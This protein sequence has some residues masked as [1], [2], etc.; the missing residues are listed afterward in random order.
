MISLETKIL[1]ASEHYF[2]RIV[3]IRR[4]LH[5]HPELSFEEKNTSAYVF[6]ILKDLGLDVKAGLGGYGLVAV[7]EGDENGPCI[8][9]RADMDALPIQE[10]NQVSYKSKNEGVMHACGH[11]AHTA[12]LLGTLMILCELRSELKGSV[13][14]IFQPG[15]EKLPGGASL[16]IKDKVLEDPKVDFM[17]GQHVFPDMKA[18]EFGVC[19]GP[20]MASTDEV[21]IRVKGKGGHGAMP[22]KCIDPVILS[23]QLLTQIQNL[24]SRITNPIEPLV[25][26]F[27]KINSVG[28]T[29]NVI[30]DEVLL[31]GTIRT[32][33]ESVRSNV[34]AKLKVLVEGLELS[35]GAS[36]ELEIRNGYPS[37]TNNEGLS[38]QVLELGKQFRGTNN[39]TLIPKRMTGEDFAYFSNEVPSCFYRMGIRNEQKG[40]TSGVHTNTFDIDEIA[41]KHSSA[42]MAFLALSLLKV[43][44]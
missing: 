13:K 24:V 19:P 36:I 37:L 4:H 41:L 40:I 34:H 2:D 27:G 28:G 18:G 43:K 22:H 15:E 31:E 11:D 35:S 42:M 1:N 32:L 12:S 9:L 16:M 38:K 17:L 23:A 21:F 8:G 26:S 20:Y 44:Y 6:Q 30:P 10:E 3:A 14:F 25:V 7:L 29:T 33:N 39:F 5:M